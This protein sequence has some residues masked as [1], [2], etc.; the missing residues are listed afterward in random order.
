LSFDSD[1]VLGVIDF[2]FADRDS[3]QL[4]R[5]SSENGGGQDA[6]NLR[7]KVFVQ[8]SWIARVLSSYLVF[9]KE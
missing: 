7:V 2:G 5:P 6:R 1:G 3:R 8:S 4:G 9:L